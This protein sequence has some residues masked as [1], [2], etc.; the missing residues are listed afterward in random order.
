MDGGVVIL[1]D[2]YQGHPPD[3]HRHLQPDLYYQKNHHHTSYVMAAHTLDKTTTSSAGEQM[4]NSATIVRM[5]LN[6]WSKTL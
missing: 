4:V 3:S 1:F 5:T 2:P 6:S